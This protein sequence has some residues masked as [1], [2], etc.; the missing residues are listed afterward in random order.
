MSNCGAGSGGYGGLKEAAVAGMG[1]GQGTP[2]AN[3][4]ADAAQAFHM[5]GQYS[6]YGAPQV[7]AAM[8]CSCSSSLRFWL[9]MSPAHCCGGH[10]LFTDMCRLFSRQC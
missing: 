5:Q 10:V 7:R 6:G 3:P 2:D 4:Y 9:H 1:G 8:S